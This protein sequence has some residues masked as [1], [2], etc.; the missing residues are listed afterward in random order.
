[1][2]EALLA[3]EERRKDSSMPICCCF[4]LDK[5]GQYEFG[6][7][8]CATVGYH[9]CN[10]C[11]CAVHGRP[12]AAGGCRRCREAGTEATCTHWDMATPATKQYFEDRE[13]ALAERVGTLPDEVLPFWRNKAEATEIARKLKIKLKSGAKLET[14]ESAIR[15]KCD[16]LT[17]RGADVPSNKRHVNRAPDTAVLRDARRWA[18][19]SGREE[20]PKPTTPEAWKQLRDAHRVLLGDAERLL[21]V[22]QVLKFWEL[23]SPHD[24][25][26]L[27]SRDGHLLDVTKIIDCALHLTL[28][29]VIH[30]L[31]LLYKM[32]L[33]A[34]SGLLAAEIGS[35]L[36]R[37]TAAIQTGLD[38]ASF[39]HRKAKG[40]DAAAW[41]AGTTKL[42]VF[43]MPAKRAK[44]IVRTSLICNSNRQIITVKHASSAGGETT[45][46]VDVGDGTPTINVSLLERI[47][48]ELLPDDAR[49]P[50]VKLFLQELI[51]VLHIVNT[52]SWETDPSMPATF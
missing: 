19:A 9:L 25:G 51:F 35:R 48:E 2:V 20:P 37:A 39:A 26:R 7:F 44:K 52:K 10:F 42:R 15:G 17:V 3:E 23:L 43:S 38:S 11:P 24:R 28:R 45:R 13:K 40:S 33:H 32:P 18:K 21:H 4:T 46:I 29:V 34:Q 16:C 47:A 8:R 36:D 5:V 27:V 14:I 49:L 41:K 30:T 50:K 6:P 31:S 12:R 22:R 1:M